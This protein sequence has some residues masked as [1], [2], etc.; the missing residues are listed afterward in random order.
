MV[1][2]E[3]R[4]R[5][6]EIFIFICAGASTFSKKAQSQGLKDLIADLYYFVH[7]ISDFI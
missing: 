5:S 6:D 4:T 7:Y 3:K 2:L 1:T